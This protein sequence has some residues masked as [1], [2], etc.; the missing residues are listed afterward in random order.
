MAHSKTIQFYRNNTV[1]RPDTQNNKTAFTV[2]K[3]SFDSIDNVSDG[4]AV[5][6]RYREGDNDPVKTIVGVYHLNGNVGSWTLIQDEL[7]SGDNIKTLGSETLV[8]SGNVTPTIP[9]AQ[10]DSTSTS[11]AYT[12]TVSGITELKD[13]VCCILKNGVV[14]SAEGFTININNLGAKPSYS[15]MATGNPVTPTNPTRDTTIFNINYVMLFIYNSTIVEGGAWICYRGY[16]ANTNTIGYQLRGNSHTL[17]TTSKFYRY[18]LLFTSAD[19]THFVPANTSSS[20]NATS[21][22]TVNQTPIDPFGEI[23]YYSSSTAISAESS[24][25]A[26]AI[27]TQYVLTVGYSFNR[28]G[29][30]L[31]LPHPKP[32]YVKCAPQA[33][34]SAIIDS[35]TPYVTELPNT[36]DGNIYI[37]LGDTYSATQIELVNNHP[38]YY[39]DGTGIREWTGHTFATV[40]TSGSYSDL[41]GAPTVANNLT[42]T[43]S[44]SVL[45]A[46]QGKELKDLIDGKI[47]TTHPANSITSQMINDLNSLEDAEEVV[48]QALSDLDERI[49]N[50]DR[51]TSD[52]EERVDA[53]EDGLSELT[54]MTE[55]THAELL[56]LKYGNNLIPG[57]NYRITDY[58][59]TTTLPNTRSGNHPFDVVVMALDESTLCED[60]HAIRHEGDTYFGDCNLSA[61]ELKYDIDGTSRSSWYSPGGT[62][63]YTGNYENFGE[64]DEEYS[65]VDYNEYYIYV[66]ELE[67][68]NSTYSLWRK[69][70]PST[71]FLD[72]YILTGHIDD[73]FDVSDDGQGAIVPSY[74][75]TIDNDELIEY[76]GRAKEKNPIVLAEIQEGGKGV[77]YYMK[78]EFGNSCY[79]DFKGIEFFI[80]DTSNS[81]LY[82][83]NYY[84]TFSFF[85]GY[86]ASIQGRNRV[87]NVTIEKSDTLNFITFTNIEHISNIHIGNGCRNIYVVSNVGGVSY[88]LSIDGFEIGDNCVDIQ[89]FATSVNNSCIKSGCNHQKIGVNMLNSTIENGVFN[90]YIY[91]GG[92]GLRTV[93]NLC[94]HKSVRDWSYIFGENVLSELHVGR[95]SN[96]D[97]VMW[98]PADHV[99]PM[100]T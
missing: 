74:V 52:V 49:T 100:A 63:L 3:E 95:N 36:N 83:G 47:S 23:V 19:G 81:I 10:V 88:N 50:N 68:N 53:L 41:S 40:A 8:G 43:E 21:S 89:I 54:H 13:G 69:Y 80:Q 64:P 22:R 87:N 2:A 27:W 62:I 57:M 11:T 44:G 65:G 42:T 16:D 51:I 71:G 67:F 94:V 90:L 7:V 76:N 38:V 85:P 5:F 24:P 48:A 17:P 99:L 46:R 86:D 70:N 60:A 30:T 33:N 9:Y 29:S 6:V 77:I 1:V 31:A 79:Y 45:D 58:V 72:T 96:G 93:S 26:T 73:D 91:N 82:N 84:Y 59:A 61:W 78:D 92:A 18:R 35:T 32:F 39:H 34:G 98:N 4:E 28:T 56:Q 12:A 15:N 25:S 55:V 66:S 20:T 37:F 97:I 14:T 75:L